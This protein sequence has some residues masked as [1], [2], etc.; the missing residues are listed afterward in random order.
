MREKLCQ[1]GGNR[2]DWIGWEEV[3][4]SGCGSGSVFFIKEAYPTAQ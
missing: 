2:G 4:D 3:E 1:V